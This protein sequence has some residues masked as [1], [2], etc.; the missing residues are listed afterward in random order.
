MKAKLEPVLKVN[1]MSSDESIVPSE[2]SDDECYV[3]QKKFRVSYLTWRSAEFQKYIDSL[4]R[5]IK[6]NQSEWSKRMTIQT[7][8]GGSSTGKPPNDCPDWACIGSL[9]DD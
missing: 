6:R 8:R 1:Y 4:D 2:N 5:K 9:M 3:P 7:E